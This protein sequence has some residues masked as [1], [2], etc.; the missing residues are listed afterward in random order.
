MI[1]QTLANVAA[2]RARGVAQP[3]TGVTHAPKISKNDTLLDW[4]RAATELERAVR[5]FRPV[6]GA[7]TTLEGEPIKIWRARV[8]DAQLAPGTLTSNLVV[9]CGQDALEV[10]EL[11][12]AGGKKLPATE[13]LRGYPLPPEARFA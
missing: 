5:A 3:Q 6:P 13:F 7:L 1:V 9:G 12:R 10:L 11:Q 8:V 4:G 2:G